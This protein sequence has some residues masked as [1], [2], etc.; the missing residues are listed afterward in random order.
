MQTG[1]IYEKTYQCIMHESGPIKVEE[2]LGPKYGKNAEIFCQIQL[3][4][5]SGVE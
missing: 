3:R 5:F 4:L 1:F 2:Q